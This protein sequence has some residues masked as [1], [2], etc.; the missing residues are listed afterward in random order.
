MST[1]ARKRKQRG[2]RRTPERA[3]SEPR[4]PARQPGTVNRRSPLRL[5][6]Q[7]MRV[8]A[9]AG[10]VAATVLGSGGAVPVVGCVDAERGELSAADREAAGAQSR[11]SSVVAGTIIVLERAAAKTKREPVPVCAVTAVRTTVTIAV[12]MPACR[13]I[14]FHA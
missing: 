6:R 4:G 11:S 2:I 14:R 10:T 8:V 13:L 1:V 12:D 3:A 9:I 5:E 7:V